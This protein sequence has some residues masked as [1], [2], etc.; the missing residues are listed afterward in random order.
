M[1]FENKKTVSFV[2]KVRKSFK[3]PSCNFLAVSKK[4]KKIKIES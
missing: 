3:L 1:S 4:K 2:L